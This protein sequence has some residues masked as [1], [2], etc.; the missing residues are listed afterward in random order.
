MLGGSFI[1]Q[2]VYVRITG[3]YDTNTAHNSASAK[4]KNRKKIRIDL[5]LIRYRP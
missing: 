4:S 5:L 1:E 3:N 2:L